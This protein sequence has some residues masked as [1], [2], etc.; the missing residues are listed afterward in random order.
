MMLEPHGFYENPRMDAMNGWIP[1]PVDPSSLTTNYDSAFANN[2]HSNHS[3]YILPTPI[4]QNYNLAIF[5]NVHV[6]PG[7]STEDIP[8]T[9]H[10]QYYNAE[11]LGNF[12]SNFAFV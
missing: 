2:W 10:D 1:A 5:A 11:Y 3:A 8:H 4:E 7:I 6:H 12:T 9:I